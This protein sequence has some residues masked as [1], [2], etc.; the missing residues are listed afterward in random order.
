MIY[1]YLSFNYAT[2][3]PETFL[4]RVGIYGVSV[5]YILSGLTLFIVYES[6]FS[7]KEFLIKRAFR[8]F[9]LL[10]ITIFL[11]IFLHK[12]SPPLT[13]IAFN[14]SGLSVL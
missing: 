4:G 5:F 9:P 1:H 3:G 8:I 10:W 7:V 2:P 14:L 11:T 12:L 6:Q 13:T